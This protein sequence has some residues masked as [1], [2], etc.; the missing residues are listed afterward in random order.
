M[1]RIVGGRLELQ[2][3]DVD[4]AS[5]ARE[6]CERFQDE[7]EKFGSQMHLSI[8]A[9]VIGRW[10]PLR[11]DQVLTNLLSNALKYGQGDAI[12]VGVKGAPDAAHIHVRD[13][14]IG[15]APE[16]RDRIFERFERAVSNR[17]FGGLG[18]GL[19]ISRQLVE[20]MGG[21]IWAESEPTRGTRFIVEL[22]R[23]SATEEA[24]PS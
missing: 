6:V 12:E 11:L 4:L 24:R 22:P 8:D 3:E 16:D 10:D 2:P 7:A 23:V 21:R 13:H 1:S 20:A 14:G 18:L 19:W 15:I 5:V 9:S 17:N